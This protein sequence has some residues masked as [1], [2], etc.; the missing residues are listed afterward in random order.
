MSF[1]AVAT[2]K[3]IVG[4]ESLLR[5]YIRQH[6]SLLAAVTL[7]F[8]WLQAPYLMCLLLLLLFFKLSELHPL[9]EFFHEKRVVPQLLWGPPEAAVRTTLRVMAA[10]WLLRA[11]PG[12]WRAWES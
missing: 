9:C 10:K 12:I 4:F 6:A 7:V 5:V 11:S 8:P 2:G 3:L 1:F